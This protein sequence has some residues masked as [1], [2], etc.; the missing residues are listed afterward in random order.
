MMDPAK[1][2]M[3]TY[4]LLILLITV[5][6]RPNIRTFLGKH[7]INIVVII[8]YCYYCYYCYFRYRKIAGD[9][10]V[11]GED[12]FFLPI[13]QDCPLQAPTDIELRTIDNVYSVLVEDTVN[14]KFTQGQVNGWS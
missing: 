2:S 12:T 14:F 4:I 11:Q 13:V 9:K 8:Y 7:Y 3:A 6:N 5:L 10:C 1:L